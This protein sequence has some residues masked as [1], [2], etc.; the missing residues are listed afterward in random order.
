[1]GDRGDRS[2]A[3]PA[4]PAGRRSARRIEDHARE[5]RAQD[6]GARCSQSRGG[7]SR[8]QPSL[9]RRARAH[10][11][12]PAAARAVAAKGDFARVAQILANLI[13]NAAKYTN[14]GG[15]ISVTAA[16]EGPNVVFRVRDTGIGIPGELLSSIFEPFTQI[17]RS[18]ARSQG[19]LGIG[20]TLVRRLVEMQGG[21]VFASSEGPDRGSEFTVSLPAAGPAQRAKGASGESG[22]TA[23]AALD[24][25]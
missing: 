3:H 15:R 21:R 9:R 14:Q 13:N 17:D 6:R 12:G 25:C 23:V 16:R 2:S 20:L 22:R 11:H 8:D 4:R 24:L 18:L 7:G 19:G 10:A 1:M 5:D